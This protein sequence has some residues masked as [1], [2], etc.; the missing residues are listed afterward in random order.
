MRRPQNLKKISHLF[1]Q[2]SCFYSVVS[3]QVED[4]FKFFWPSQKNWTLNVWPELFCPEHE[5]A[6]FHLVFFLHLFLFL[7]YFLFFYLELCNPYYPQCVLKNRNN[8]ANSLFFSCF[9][10]IFRKRNLYLHHSILKLEPNLSKTNN[11]IYLPYI[12]SATYNLHTTMLQLSSG[13]FLAKIWH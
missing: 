5:P 4:F 3:K 12:S 7:V 8:D 13:Y 11:Q 2:S 10:E 9:F 6:F 1:W